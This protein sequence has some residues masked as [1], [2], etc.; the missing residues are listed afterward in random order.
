MCLLFLLLD[1]TKPLG[2]GEVFPEL[3][4]LLVCRHLAVWCYTFTYG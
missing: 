1:F 4:V 2:F 3:N